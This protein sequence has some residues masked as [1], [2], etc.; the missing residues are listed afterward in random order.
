MIQTIPTYGIY[1]DWYLS[2][3]KD[4]TQRT[5]WGDDW[6]HDNINFITMKN[7]MDPEAEEVESIEKYLID[8]MCPNLVRTEH[9]FHITSIQKVSAYKNQ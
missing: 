1:S 7:Y 9:T 4:A 5:H 6:S 3:G 8:F 2:S